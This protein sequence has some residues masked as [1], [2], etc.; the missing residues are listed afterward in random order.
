MKK[1]LFKPTDISEDD[2]IFGVLDDNG[3]TKTLIQA[4]REVEKKTEKMEKDAY[5]KKFPLECSVG[6]M[7]ADRIE[8]KFITDG[9]LCKK[10]EF[11]HP[12]TV[13]QLKQTS[14]LT[15]DPS[16]TAYPPYLQ[17]TRDGRLELGK[18][19][20][21]HRGPIMDAPPNSKTDLC[22]KINNGLYQPR[23]TVCKECF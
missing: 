13:K 22:T 17:V 1:C 9:Y 3:V 20:L 21:L 18:E 6:R 2:A 23:Q 11:V 10:I 4:E 5:E 14:N 19:N 8:S 12:F 15:K 7:A 16:I